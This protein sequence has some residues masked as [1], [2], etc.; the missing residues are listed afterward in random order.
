MHMTRVASGRREVHICCGALG[1]LMIGVCSGAGRAD[2]ES[3]GSIAWIPSGGDLAE[4]RRRSGH[5]VWSSDPP[6]PDMTPAVIRGTR[7]PSWS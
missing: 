7:A 5:A 6:G 1:Y 3:G 4:R 2:G